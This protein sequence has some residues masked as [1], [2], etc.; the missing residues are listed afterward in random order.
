MSE[1]AFLPS[2][3][4]QVHV[5][6]EEP[7]KPFAD[8]LRNG[9]WSLA[10]L[11]DDAVFT[12]QYQI[13]LD[14]Q[15]ILVHVDNSHAKPA[16]S[17]FNQTARISYGGMR[18][19]WRIVQQK[20]NYLVYENFAGREGSS[21]D[22]LRHATTRNNGET[23]PILSQI[24]AR[25]THQDEEALDL[26]GAQSLITAAWETAQRMKTPVAY[27]F[28]GRYE[29]M[30]GRASIRAG[31]ISPG[32]RE[33]P[34]ADPRDE[35]FVCLEADSFSYLEETPEGSQYFKEK[36]NPLLLPPLTEAQRKRQ[37]FVVEANRSRPGF[38]VVRI[39][40]NQER[41]IQARFNTQEEA[42]A[43]ADRRYAVLLAKAAQRPGS[44]TDEQEERVIRQ[45]Y[46]TV[47]AAMN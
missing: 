11:N 31:G 32:L 37:P 10:R 27:F 14:G 7:Q 6:S 13:P 23:Y 47:Y 26:A 15:N 12:T 35:L 34:S 42:Q 22:N 19:V 36:I 44:L 16:S 1:Q 5:S 45:L 46:A 9:L 3:E 43:E 8:R 25:I 20:S 2:F 28:T 29:T 24:A 33:D 40:Q 38:N 18:G 39:G 17:H 21:L 4:Q 41:R 30:L